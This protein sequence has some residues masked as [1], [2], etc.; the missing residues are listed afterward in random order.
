MKLTSFHLPPEVFN[1]VYDEYLLV[2]L[3]PLANSGNSLL[4]IRNDSFHINSPNFQDM[5]FL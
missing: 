4:E 2:Q 5:D 1:L 3:Y